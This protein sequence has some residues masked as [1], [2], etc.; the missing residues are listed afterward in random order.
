MYTIYEI[1]NIKIGCSQNPDQ[2]VKDQGHNNWILLEQHEDIIVASIRELQLQIEK[3]YRVDRI[4]YYETVRRGGEGAK[5]QLR[6]GNHNFQRGLGRY[7]WINKDHQLRTSTLGGLANKGIPKP[8]AKEMAKALNIEWTCTYCNKSG[9]GAGN[10]K[11]Y[12][13]DQCKEKP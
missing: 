2:R 9:K 5:S 7:G 1:P 3:G 4:P 12:H 6:S 11:W 13:G 8:H 10:F